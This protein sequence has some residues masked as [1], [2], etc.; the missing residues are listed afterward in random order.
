[1]DPLLALG[2]FVGIPVALAA[3]IA[4]LVVSP[5]GSYSQ[6][7]EQGEQG[8]E[9]LSPGAVL[10]TSAPATPNPA[11]LPSSRTDPGATAGGAR[12]NW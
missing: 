2:L 9:E 7:G 12:G 4:V 10:I 1:M 8:E 6:Q 3:V 11:A 5:R